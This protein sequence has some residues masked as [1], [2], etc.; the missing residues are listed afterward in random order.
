M[1]ILENIKKISTNQYKSALSVFHH[2][3]RSCTGFS[4]YISAIILLVISTLSCTQ[5]TERLPIYGEREPIEKIV[6]GKKVVDTLYNTIPD[7]K[8]ISQNQD[9]I[10]AK[11]LD[12]KIYVADFFFTTCPTICPVM[13]RQMLKVYKEIEGDDDVMI[14]SHTIDPQHDTPEVLAKYAR[15][16]GVSG[17]Q[18]LFVTGNREA[19]YDIGQKHYMVVAGADS[20]APGGYIHSGAFILVD[21]QKRVR[22]LYDGTTKKGAEQLLADIEK[23]RDEYR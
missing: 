20:T 1:T 16:L 15:D 2:F 14:L 17:G 5:S 21:K 19:I 8:F 10:T 3:Q 12:G 11:T 18:W 6:N 23:L 4:S 9:T 22:G 13:K 7:F